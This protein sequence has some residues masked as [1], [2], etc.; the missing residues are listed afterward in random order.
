MI[1]G[2]FKS[3]CINIKKNNNSNEQPGRDCEIP[4][5]FKSQKQNYYYDNIKSYKG[6]KRNKVG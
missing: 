1:T 2:N 5:L 3:I 4:G 6:Y